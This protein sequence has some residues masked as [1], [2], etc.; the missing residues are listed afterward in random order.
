M[1]TGRRRCPILSG[2]DQLCEQNLDRRD[3]NRRVM[4]GEVS[5]EQPGQSGTKRAVVRVPRAVLEAP[6]SKVCGCMRKQKLVFAPT[7][8]A[9]PIW[10][11]TNLRV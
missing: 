4:P 2:W 10:Q 6:R 1:G 11:R 7:R 3:T 9:R 8:V 5:E